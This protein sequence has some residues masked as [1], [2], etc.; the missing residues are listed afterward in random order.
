VRTRVTEIAAH[1][2]REEG[3]AALSMRRI[4]REAGVSVMGLYDYF[5]SKNEIIRSMWERFFC[6]C[7]DRVDAAVTDCDGKPRQRLEAACAAYTGYWLD[8]PDQY[9]AVFMIEDRVESQERYY[10]ETSN[11]L[12]RYAVF[13]RLLDELSGAPDGGSEGP[14]ARSVALICALNGICHMLVTVSEHTW[15]PPAHLLEQVLRMVDGPS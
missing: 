10:V 9:R 15:P 12:E 6:R 2:F 14:R 13:R 8:H 7:F 4:A 1:L 11:I 5:R 3:I